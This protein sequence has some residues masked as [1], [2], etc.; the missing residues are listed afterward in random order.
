MKITT[1]IAALFVSLASFAG[2]DGSDNQKAT[3]NDSNSAT[4][5]VRGTVVD[6]Q[7]G[8]PLAGVTVTMENG[9]ETFTDFDGNF[10]FNNLK[11]GSY[12][13]ETSLIS[14]ENITFNNVRIDPD[15]T[16]RLSISLNTL[17]D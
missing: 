7:T 8:D 12:R 16:Q 10:A 9:Q 3:T 17:N 1:F 15:G 14:Y 5:M 4:C 13:I 11:P 6:K 2:I